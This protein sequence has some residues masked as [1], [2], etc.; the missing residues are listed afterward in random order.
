MRTSMTYPIR[1][2]ALLLAGLLL[3]QFS[4]EALAD[5][6]K[7]EK[8]IDQNLDLSSAEMLSI[9][10]AAGDLDVVGVAGTEQAVI[11]GRACA[12]KEKWL[13]QS[14]LITSP[15]RQASIKVKLPEING[16]WSITGNSYV[17]MDLRVEVPQ[18]LALDVKDSSGDVSLENTASVTVQDSSGDIEIEGVTGMVSIKDSSGDIEVDGIQGDLTIESDSSGDIYAENID[19]TFLVEKDSSGDIDARGVTGNVVVERDSSGDINAK[20]VGGDFLVLKDGSGRITSRDIEGDVRVP[21]K[22]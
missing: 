1:F 18:G 2:W 10:A 19:G 20:D 12:S 5:S 9:L 21:E 13:D 22:G 15:G 11:T 8:K 14:A 3:Y 17:W 7:Y 4:S 16:G 6:C